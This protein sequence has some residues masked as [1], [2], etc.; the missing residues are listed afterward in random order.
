MGSHFSSVLTPLFG[1]LMNLFERPMVWAQKRLGQRRIAWLF[2]AP[3]LLIFG[4]FTFLP[5]ILNFY[6]ATT[7]GVKILPEDRVYVGADNFP[8]IAD[9]R[10]L[11]EPQQ[12]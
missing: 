12:L 4:L 10:R 5:I 6:Y 2:L 11:S 3:N 1:A 8:R 9:L 7:G